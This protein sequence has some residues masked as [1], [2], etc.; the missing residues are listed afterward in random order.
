MVHTDWAKAF[1]ALSYMMP[2]HAAGLAYTVLTAF[3]DKICRGVLGDSGEFQ[4]CK[5]TISLCNQVL[6]IPHMGKSPCNFPLQC[7]LDSP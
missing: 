3:C 7:S 6:A 5:I 2:L 1:Y 4:I